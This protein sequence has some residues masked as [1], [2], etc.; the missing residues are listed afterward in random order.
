MA[1]SKMHG[2]YAV[3]IGSTVLK[4]ITSRALRTGAEVRQMPTSGEVYARFQALYSVKPMAEFAS[5]NIA[6]ALDLCSLTGTALTSAAPLLFYAQKNT[7][8]GTRTAGSV[9]RIYTMN[10]GILVP[11][12][13]V[14]EHQQDAEIQYEALCTYDGTNEPLTI[15]DTSAL[16][17][18]TGDAE[19]FTLG[20]ITLKDDSDNIVVFSQVRRLEIDL[21]IQAET[22]GADSDIF[23]T[24]CRIVE[25]QPSIKITGIDIEWFKAL[26]TGIP[27]TGKSVKHSGTEIILRKRTLGGQY[28]AAAT[29]EHIGFTAAG[30]ATIEQACG[31]DG[32]A[33]DE[34]SITMPLK[35][36]GTNNPLVIDTTYGYT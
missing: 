19:R 27:L 31:A 32:N 17:A 23:D 25:I 36:D 20:R 1:V 14:V 8:G 3:K 28:V 18:L 15:T 29:Q 26:A 35:F 13:I 34:V 22:V 2:I 12:K 5:R 4:G 16:P 7:E 30:M 21:G 11:R 33:L 24:N 9:H 10:E 6:A